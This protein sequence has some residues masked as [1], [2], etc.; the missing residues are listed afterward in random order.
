M[1]LKSWA[2]EKM[3][4]VEKGQ[5]RRF[6]LK[7]QGVSERFLFVII[8]IWKLRFRNIWSRL[9]S[10][11]VSHAWRPGDSARVKKAWIGA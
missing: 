10:P 6:V 5:G 1:R 2:N 4:W 8:K 7:G 9:P 11:H 3:S